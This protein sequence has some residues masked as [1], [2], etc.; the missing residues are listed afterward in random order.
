MEK[1]DCLQYLVFGVCTQELATVL[2]EAG[3]EGGYVDLQKTQEAFW[4]QQG[5]GAKNISE[6][7]ESS[8]G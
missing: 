5:T 1:Q 7:T 6:T 4:E 2:A 3:T 8:K